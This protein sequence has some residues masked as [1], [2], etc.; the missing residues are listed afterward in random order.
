M[1]AHRVRWPWLLIGGALAV[2]PL[3][4]TGSDD[5]V[6]IEL[7]ETTPF[8]TMLVEVITTTSGAPTTAPVATSAG[9]GSSTSV[10][11]LGTYT[12]V[13]GDYWIG[14]ADKLGVTLE[15]LLAANAATTESFLS[16]G[17]ALRV[18]AGATVTSAPPETPPVSP[19]AS[20]AGGTYTVVAGDYWILIAE[21][22]RVA[23]DALLAANDATTDTFLTP[24]MTLAVP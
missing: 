20:G 14:I 8:R 13:A 3:A 10:G 4:C 17:Q 2:V 7:P 9:S 11:P 24:G 23:L 18:P 16:P 6:G 12:V 1:A 15:A 19:P 22:L 21:K 5:P